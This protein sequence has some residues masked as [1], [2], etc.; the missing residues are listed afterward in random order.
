VNPF[1]SS[2][3]SGIWWNYESLTVLALKETMALGELVSKWG[4]EKRVPGALWRR[5]AARRAF[6]TADEGE[7]RSGVEDGEETAGLYAF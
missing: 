6:Y 2:P 4:S 5:H 1:S 3:R 7:L